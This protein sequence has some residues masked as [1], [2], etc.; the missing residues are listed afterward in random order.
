MKKIAFICELVGTPR[1]GGENLAMLRTANALRAAGLS[2]DVFTYR[3]DNQDLQI[4]SNIPLKLRLLPFAREMFFAPHVGY[5]LLKQFEEKYDAVFAS[6]M[7]IASLFK[8][9]N[10]L[11][12]TCHLIRSQKFKNLSKIPKYKLLFNPLTYKIM[13]TLEKK[14][15]ENAKNIIVIRAQQKEYLQNVLGIDPKKIIHISNGIDIDFFKP[16]TSKKKNQIVFVGR[17]TVPKGIDTLLHAAD[18]IDAN[19]LIVTQK[20]DKEFLELSK[21]KANVQIKLKAT[22][23]EMVKI[24]AESKIFV[25]PSINEEQPLST[26]E[27]MSCGL[28]VVVT[29]EAASDIVQ[30]TIHG[31][32]IPERDPKTL[33][34]KINLL[35]QN[36]KIMQTMSKKNRERIMETYNL[37]TITDM[38]KELIYAHSR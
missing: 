36:E 10:Q 21:T 20:I 1:E 17:G 6:T 23:E 14:S 9:K 27:A 8:P 12:I 35:L 3:S 32:I 18:D 19:I 15:L 34:E 37:K 11:V 33:S 24:Y 5:T 30:D 7:T 4:K 29:P 25:L 13:T 16:I 26:L 22:P 2:V 28:P 31:F 38:T